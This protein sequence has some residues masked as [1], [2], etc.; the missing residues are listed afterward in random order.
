MNKQ[1]D[2]F[3]IIVMYIYELAAR[4]KRQRNYDNDWI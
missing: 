3:W 1:F 4:L 2:G